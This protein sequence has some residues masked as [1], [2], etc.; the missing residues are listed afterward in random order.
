MGIFGFGLAF[1]LT[2][3]GN[4]LE[5]N[6]F[7]IAICIVVYALIS[8]AWGTVTA[9]VVHNKG[10]YYEGTKWFWIGIIFNEIGF[11]FACTKPDLNIIS[12][13]N[14]HYKKQ[15]EEIK[16][17]EKQGVADKRTAKINL[18]VRK[19][20]TVLPSKDWK[21]SCGRTNPSYVT[22]CLCGVEK[23]ITLDDKNDKDTGETVK[24]DK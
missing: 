1:L 8:L 21:C 3:L 5:G 18:P 24:K 13:M 23:G 16:E 19:F 20:K 9:T 11:A 7:Y 15:E 10:Y 17:L 22:T 6:W 4:V 12:L 2:W 14:E